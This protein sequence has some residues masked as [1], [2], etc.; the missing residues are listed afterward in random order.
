MIG[1]IAEKRRML[2][3]IVAECPYQHALGHCYLSSIRGQPAK[4]IKA[5][6]VS[7]PGKALNQLLDRHHQCLTE[8]Q[9]VRL[10]G[11]YIRSLNDLCD[12]PDE[13]LAT[14]KRALG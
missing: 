2:T 13:L 10:Q 4:E 1:S 5:W 7:L 3:G 12:A 9:I 6:L 8:R 11:D 14:V